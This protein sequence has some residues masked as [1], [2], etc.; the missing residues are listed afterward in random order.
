MKK[1]GI[2]KHK[3]TLKARGLIGETGDPV[4][5]KTKPA[6]EKKQIPE[7]TFEERTK[8]LTEVFTRF[9]RSLNKRPENAIKYL[10]SRR[11]DYKKLSIGFDAGT[12]HSLDRKLQPFFN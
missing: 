2:S 11:L 4:L 7:L 9:A 3:A 12:L 6:P 8:L 10:E 5:G 1:E